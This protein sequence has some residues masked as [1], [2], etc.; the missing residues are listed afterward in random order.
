MDMLRIC[1]LF[2]PPLETKW[3][4]FKFMQE[5]KVP[6]EKD[7]G[8]LYVYFGKLVVVFLVRWLI[9]LPLQNERKLIKLVFFSINV[10]FYLLYT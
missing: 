4:S 6:S 7:N 5:P 3:Y 9:S 1:Y 2:Q 8:I 10:S